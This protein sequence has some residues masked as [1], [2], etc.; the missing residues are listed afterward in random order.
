[1]FQSER[2]SV[3]L[4]KTDKAQ[5]QTNSP[6]LRK[7]TKSTTANSIPKSQTPN[8]SPE[9]PMSAHDRATRSFRHKTNYDSSGKKTRD[10]QL[11]TQAPKIFLNKRT[12]N[13]LLFS[14]HFRTE[15]PRGETQYTYQDERVPTYKMSS[16]KSRKRRSTQN[17]ESCD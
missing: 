14:E 12:P 8:S 3:Q 2:V 4:T 7:N 9:Q 1:M 15:R 13:L 5:T 10:V 6:N 17:D 16:S 11:V